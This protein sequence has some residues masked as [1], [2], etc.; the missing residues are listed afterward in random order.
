MYHIL[1]ST[2]TVHIEA[3]LIFLIG[4][5]TYHSILHPTFSPSSTRHIV[6]RLSQ[7]LDIPRRDARHTDPAILGR[8]HAVLLG[9]RVHLLRLEPRVREHA[10]LARDVAPVVLAAQLLQVLLQKRPHLDDPVRHPL[11]LA[12][13]LLVERWVVEDRAGYARAVHGRVRVQRSHEDLDLRVDTLFLVRVRTDDG[14]CADTLA[15]QTLR[16][17]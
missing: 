12:Q 16:M 11:D 15:V 4:S 1:T 2:S 9:Q 7:P 3:F 14:E 17:S 10:D 13:P 5:S 6:N 8:I